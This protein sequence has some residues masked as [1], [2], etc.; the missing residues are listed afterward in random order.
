MRFI[1]DDITQPWD[2]P[3]N[4]FDFI[5]VRCLAGSIT[6]W[7]EFLA[8]A[9]RYAKDWSNLYMRLGVTSGIYVLCRHLKPGGT[10]ELSEGRTHMVCDDGTY[11]ETS[12]T[13][14]WIVRCLNCLKMHT[15]ICILTHV[16]RPN[17]I[18]YQTH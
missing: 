17:S 5:H 7:P 14:K 8:Q 18:E 10:I 6:D 1:I 16:S 13:Y 15:R 2:F 3:I 9:Y 11:P 4:S 12:F